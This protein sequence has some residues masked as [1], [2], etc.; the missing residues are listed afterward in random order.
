MSLGHSAGLDGRTILLPRWHMLVLCHSLWWGSLCSVGSELGFQGFYVIPSLF[1]FPIFESPHLRLLI[2]S[3]FGLTGVLLLVPLHLQIGY[4]QLK[5][6]RDRS[7]GG[8]S[9]SDGHYRSDNWAGNRRSC[10]GGGRGSSLACGRARHG[11]AVIGL[12]KSL[13][14]LKVPCWKSLLP[15]IPPILSL[16]EGC[17]LRNP[18]LSTW[19]AAGS[20]LGFRGRVGGTEW[21][22]HCLLSCA[23]KN[24]RMQPS[25]AT[26]GCISLSHFRIRPPHR[27]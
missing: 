24:A 21:T 27:F 19:G 13:E 10:H 3:K 9:G 25:D 1:Q 2:L 12:L 7:Q 17:S 4:L 16:N 18:A 22:G 6:R 20:C 5:K 8:G 23:T 11:C 14:P 15:W 26:F